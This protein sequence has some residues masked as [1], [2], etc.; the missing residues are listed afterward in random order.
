MTAKELTDTGPFTGQHTY[1]DAFL[2]L[3]DKKLATG[4]SDKLSVI[5][6]GGLIRNLI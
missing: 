5:M 4:L 2:L 6:A 3:G 1:E